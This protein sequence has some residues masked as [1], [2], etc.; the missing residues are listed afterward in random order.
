MIKSNNQSGKE[1]LSNLE[2]TFVEKKEDIYLVNDSSLYF[3]IKDNIMQKFL[4]Y[5]ENKDSKIVLYNNQGDT[6]EY[7]VSELCPK[8]FDEEDLK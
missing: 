7:T 6:E 1:E 4:R 3:S 8:P 2:G 5:I